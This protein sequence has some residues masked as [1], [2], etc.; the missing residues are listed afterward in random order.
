M[1]VGVL[2]FSELYEVELVFVEED[3][4]GEGDEGHGV[5]FVGLVYVE[6]GV[7]E[8]GEAEVE[9]AE[10]EVDAHGCA[11]GH[12]DDEVEGFAVVGEE[13]LV[14]DRHDRVI[15]RLIISLIANYQ[16]GKI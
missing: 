5:E 9:H 2:C 8:G 7:G 11:E 14:A 15:I 4:E 10:D 6:V 3:D 16:N 1:C 13:F 12:D